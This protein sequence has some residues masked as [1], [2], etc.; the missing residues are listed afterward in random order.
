MPDNV[1][2]LIAAARVQ[3]QHAHATWKTSGLGAAMGGEFAP[4]GGRL[5]VAE[6]TRDR[7]TVECVADL[8]SGSAERT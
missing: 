2:A 1:E 4:I 5:L 3:V 8:T 6:L 7:L